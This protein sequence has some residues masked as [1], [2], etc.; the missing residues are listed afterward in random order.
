LIKHY[1]IGTL[2]WLSAL[3]KFSISLSLSPNVFF[4]VLIFN[5]S[6]NFLN[7]VL[8]FYVC[9]INYFNALSKLGKLKNVSIF[10][11]TSENDSYDCRYYLWP[12]IAIK[13]ILYTKLLLTFWLDSS[14]SLIEG[15]T[16]DLALIYSTLK[17]L[18]LYC[19]LIQP[20]FIPNILIPYWVY[21]WSSI[22]YKSHIFFIVVEI[23][24]LISSILPP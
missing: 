1:S 6:I 9:L 3:N 7:T 8:F 21:C 4:N 24:S 18:F 2:L 23:T 5:N 16:I 13:L 10:I 12:L 20:K 14:T 11:Y 17:V 22:T 19:L 15:N